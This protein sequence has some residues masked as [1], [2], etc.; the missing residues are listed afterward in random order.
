MVIDPRERSQRTWGAHR[1]ESIEAIGGKDGS[2]VV[3]PIGS[4]EQHGRHLPT[5]TDTI[6]VNEV[7]HLG[8]DRVESDVPILLMPPIWTG[9]SPHHL[10]FGGTI[11]IGLDTMLSL[12]EDV[13]ASALENG[14]DALLLVNGHG[15][16]VSIVSNLVSEIG[17]EHPSVDVH[18]VTYFTLADSFIDDVR[19]SERGGMGHGGEFETSLMLYLRPELVHS[20]S[21]EGTRRETTYSHGSADMFDGGSLSSYNDFS[22][23][24][25]SG[26]IGDPELGTAEKGEEIYGR[27]GDQMETLLREIHRSAKE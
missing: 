17:I 18:G 12:V 20:D 5:G 14:F 8:A 27:L 10:P 3:V 7:A 13:A 25:A 11:T 2:V 19:E 15:G 22:E 21:M 4:H 16:N 26:A 24:S 6:L 1:A 9:Y 23:Y